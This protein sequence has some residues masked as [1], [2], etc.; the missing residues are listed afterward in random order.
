MYIRFAALL[1]V[2]ALAA[3]AAAMPNALEARWDTSQCNN[4]EIQCCNSTE[5]SNDSTVSVL[6][7]LLGIALPNV[8]GLIGLDCD[9]I[10]VI[11]AGGNSCTAQTVCCT[12][13]NFNGV[14]N[15]GCSLI[16]L[17]L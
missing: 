12:N 17:G 15:L 1:P 3:V 11:G 8:A 9:P 4:G 6:S 14:V 16:N 7:A 13:N 10:T 2:A 5:E